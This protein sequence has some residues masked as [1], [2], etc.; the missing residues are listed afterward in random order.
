VDK[1]DED[2][3]EGGFEPANALWLAAYRAKAELLSSTT[4]GGAHGF[5][6]AVFVGVLL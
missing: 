6:G 5:P 4:A 1:V 3:R 2:A